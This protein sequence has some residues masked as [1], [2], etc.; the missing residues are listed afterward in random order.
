VVA[1][2]AEAGVHRFRAELQCEDGET[3]LIEEESTRYLATSR[4]DSTKPTVRR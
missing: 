2:A 3:Q 4:S 1:Q